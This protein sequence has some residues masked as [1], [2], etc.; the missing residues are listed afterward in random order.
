MDSGLAAVA[1]NPD[2]ERVFDRPESEPPQ[3]RQRPDSCSDRCHE[4]PLKA[5]REFKT[6]AARPRIRGQRACARYDVFVIFFFGFFFV[7]V[8]AMT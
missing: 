2:D 7:G 5:P 3:K 8:V 4:T 6:L 1:A